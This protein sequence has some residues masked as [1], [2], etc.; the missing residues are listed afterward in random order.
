MFGV[1]HDSQRPF[2]VEAGNGT[3]TALGTRFQIRREPAQVT[4][5]L[6]EGSVALERL[7]SGERR[8]L[9]PGDQATS[10]DAGTPVAVRLV[11]PEVVSSWT[12]GRLLFRSKP[13]AD[14]GAEVQDGN[15]SDRERECQTG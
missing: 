15:E 9:T 7:D 2:R 13:M 4:V 10:G 6:M 1:A 11:D 14:G 12:P 8:Q 5:T 3:V